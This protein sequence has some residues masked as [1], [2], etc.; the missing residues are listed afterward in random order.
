MVAGDG[1]T[2]ALQASGDAGRGES[3][4][5][6][7]SDD[8]S[9]R[10]SMASRASSSVT[11]TIPVSAGRSSGMTIGYAAES[12]SVKSRNCFRAISRASFA[13]IR[14]LLTSSIVG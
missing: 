14:L 1:V 8:Q 9:Y 5:E 12:P 3:G 4:A 6:E 11:V 10:A 7:A 13:I 2:A